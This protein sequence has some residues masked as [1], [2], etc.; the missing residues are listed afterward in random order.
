MAKKN[1]V[2][3]FKRRRYKS[4]GSSIYFCVLDCD[5]KIEIPFAL[6]KRSIC[7]RCG[8]EFVMNKYS[9]RLAEPHCEDCN[10]QKV[11]TE[12]PTP[13]DDLKARLTR[14]LNETKTIEADKISDEPLDFL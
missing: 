12:M 7:W 4:T 2:H 3:K 13:V 8:N 11:P 9:I 5:F 1:H 14:T 6:G 10:R